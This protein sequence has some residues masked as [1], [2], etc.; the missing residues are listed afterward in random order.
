MGTKTCTRVFTGGL[1]V[2]GKQGKYLD[3]YQQRTLN[4]LQQNYI[5]RIYT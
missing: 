5:N 3:I 2:L 4:T 1:S